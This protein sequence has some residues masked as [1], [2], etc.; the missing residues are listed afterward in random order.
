MGMVNECLAT[1][2]YVLRVVNSS[3]GPRALIIFSLLN[4]LI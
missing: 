4:S 2:R 3:P 1:C